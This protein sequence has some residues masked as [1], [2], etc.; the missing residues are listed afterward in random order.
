MAPA[1]QQLP[2]RQRAC[3]AA[4]RDRDSRHASSTQM[5][6]KKPIL[7]HANIQTRNGS[8]TVRDA[9]TANVPLREQFWNHSGIHD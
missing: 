8:A 7:A 3:S 6:G 2:A 4:T 9:M 5:P 1:L